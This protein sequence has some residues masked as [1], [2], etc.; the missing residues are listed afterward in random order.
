[1]YLDDLDKLKIRRLTPKE[2]ERLQGFPDDWTE[3]GIDE[4]GYLVKNS[5]SQRYHQTGNAVTV[6]VIKAIAD[7]LS[8]TGPF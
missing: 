5:D 6:N 1:M 2:C 3:F 4:K 8:K 7:N